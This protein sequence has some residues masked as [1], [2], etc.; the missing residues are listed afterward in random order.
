MEAPRA[1]LATDV[2]ERVRDLFGPYVGPTGAR[3]LSIGA[4]EPGFVDIA[5]ASTID[6]GELACVLAVRALHLVDA[7]TEF[8]LTLRRK[9]APRGTVCIVTEYA[10]SDAAWE[11]P[12][13]RR[14]FTE[15]SFTYCSGFEVA[16]LDLIPFPDLKLGTLIGQRQQEFEVKRRFMRNVVKEMRVV[17]R[18]KG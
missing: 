18:K 17:I 6:D 16:M 10:S 15:G 9:L 1:E 3:R 5:E 12:E 8:M 4:H 7:F 11:D 14:A 13:T 2:S